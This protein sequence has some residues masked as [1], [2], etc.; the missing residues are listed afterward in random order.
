MFI[1]YPK[2][3]RLGK[4]ENDDILKQEVVIQEKL[5]GANTS[6]WIDEAGL[7]IASRNQEITS[8]FNGFVDYVKEN[9]GIQKLLSDHPN[10][11]LYG[12][13][14]VRHTISYK[15]TAYKKFY[16]FD[17][18]D[19]EKAKGKEDG[20]LSGC[21]LALEEVEQIAKKYDVP[22]PQIFTQGIVKEEDVKEFVGKTEFGELGEGVVIKSDTFVNKFGN[23]SYAKI[24][25][26]KFKENNALVFGGN[27]KYSETYW[28]MYIV[29]KYCSLARVQKI[30]NKFQPAIDERLDKK[31]T[32]RIAH[33]CYHDMITEEAWEIANKVN[34]V[35][36]K[37]LKR[38]ATKKFIQIFHDILDNN[39]SVA[40]QEESE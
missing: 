36:F 38:L 7:H 40:D 29:N 1:K 13:W 26:Q 4:E 19:I 23:H 39:I 14:L 17:I 5:D 10:Y 8:G 20:D 30:M 9:K 2:I 6:I 35:D 15:E 28:E 37:Q 27:N 32:P 12:E 3:Y 22:F 25:T 16:L 33:T 18:L 34:N 11:H 31:H 24:V 21:F